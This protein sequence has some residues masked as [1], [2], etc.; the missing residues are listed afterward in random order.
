MQEGLDKYI[1]YS[2]QNWY[3][4]SSVLQLYFSSVYKE[5][6]SKNS[7]TLQGQYWLLDLPTEIHRNDSS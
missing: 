3:V 7:L 6:K 4:Y 5:S 1:Q 2:D